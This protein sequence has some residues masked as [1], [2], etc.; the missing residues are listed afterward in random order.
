[1]VICRWKFSDTRSLLLRDNSH[2]T[3]MYNYKGSLIHPTHETHCHEQGQSTTPYSWNPLSCTGAVCYTLLIKL[4][5]V[6]RG[7][8]LHPTHKARCRWT[9][10]VCYTLLI[11]LTVMYRGSLL[12]LHPAHKAHYHEQG[13]SSTPYS[14]SSLLWTAAAYYTLLSHKAHHHEQGQSTTPYS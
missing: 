10:E 4:N 5:I 9:G 3:I 12:V 6:N 7:S 11:N 13:Q 8:L 14:W 2:D 1:M